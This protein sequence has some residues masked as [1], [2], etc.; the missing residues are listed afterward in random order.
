[1]IGP[2]RAAGSDV[3]VVAALAE[4][5]SA[6]TSEATAMG[7]EPFLRNE[8][9]RGDSSDLL[10][11]PLGRHLSPHPMRLFVPCGKGGLFKSYT[12]TM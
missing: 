11:D 2:G 4:A 5:V 12:L 7:I 3:K 1:M 8:F 9:I 10:K 6:R